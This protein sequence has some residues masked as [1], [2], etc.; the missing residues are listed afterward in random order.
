M[1]DLAAPPVSPVVWEAALGRRVVLIEDRLWVS[2][3]EKARAM[4]GGE[5]EYV[6]SPGMF[7]PPHQLWFFDKPAAWYG[8]VDSEHLAL[9]VPNGIV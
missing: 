3:R 9:R 5:P 8:S 1:K 2:A 6:H 4:L 7:V